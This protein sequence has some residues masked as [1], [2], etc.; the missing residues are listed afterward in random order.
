M[1]SVVNGPGRRI[2]VRR[3]ERRVLCHLE[4][5]RNVL[6]FVADT[7]DLRTQLPEFDLETLVAP[8][9]VINPPDHGRTGCREAPPNHSGWP[10]APISIC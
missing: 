10:S 5:I 8:V 9:E 1:N 4:S 2:E 3:S 6:R 7:L